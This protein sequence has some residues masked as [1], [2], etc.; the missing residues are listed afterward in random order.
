M[1]RMPYLRFYLL[2][3]ID[4]AVEQAAEDE[5]FERELELEDGEL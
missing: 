4:D 3:A 1:N 5:A 2:R